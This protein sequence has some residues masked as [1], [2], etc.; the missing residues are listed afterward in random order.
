MVRL[1][2]DI[3]VSPVDR[4]NIGTY[5]CLTENLLE[6]DYSEDFYKATANSDP[7]LVRIGFFKDIPVA[8]VGAKIVDDEVLYIMTLGVLPTFERLG[9]ASEMVKFLMENGKK[10]GCKHCNLHV[11]EN[12]PKGKSFYEKLGFK[13]LSFN[14]TYYTAIQP[15][16]AHFLTK[17]L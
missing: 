17:E 6:V 11:W 13:T 1:T 4:N 10:R 9:I 14:P 3:F 12:N 8:I 16:G 7:D 15:R 2:K 5:K